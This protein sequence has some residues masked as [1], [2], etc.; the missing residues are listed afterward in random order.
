MREHLK[1]VTADK[2]DDLLN[3]NKYSGQLVFDDGDDNTAG[4]LDL[5]VQKGVGSEGGKTTDVKGLR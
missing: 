3:M 5:V 1:K 2:F 4:S